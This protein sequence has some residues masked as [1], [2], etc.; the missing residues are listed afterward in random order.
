MKIITLF[1]MAALVGD[2]QTIIED[3]RCAKAVSAT[4]ASPAV[5]T[6][7]EEHGWTGRP[8]QARLAFMS[9]GVAHGTAVTIDGQTYTFVTALDNEQPRQILISG[10]RVKTAQRLVAAIT[11]SGEDKGVGYSMATTAHPT[12]AAMKPQ[13]TEASLQ[14]DLAN[15]WAIWKD[16]GL[17]TGD[18]LTV[19][20]SN[21]ATMTPPFSYYGTYYAIRIDENRFR[22]AASPED[23][24]NGVS[25]D[26]AT[27]PGGN[28]LKPIAASC[29]GCFQPW[30]GDTALIYVYV[31]SRMAGLSGTGIPVTSGN[32]AQAAWST[33]TLQIQFNVRITGATGSW[34]GLGSNSAPKNYTAT[35]VDESRFSVPFNATSAG[36]FSGQDIRIR[37]AN[38]DGSNKIYPTNAEIPLTDTMTSNHALAVHVG[39]CEPSMNEVECSKGY[40]SAD[41]QKAYGAYGNIQ[42]F[43]V[44]GKE[45]TITLK[46]SFVD[47]A[48]FE[49]LAVGELIQVRGYHTYATATNPGYTGAP[50]AA[51]QP[52]A[53]LFA[54]NSKRGFRVT[55]LSPDRKTVK[56]NNPGLAD[57]S[58]TGSCAVTGTC[59][60]GGPSSPDPYI[61]ITWRASP[62]LYLT[63]RNGGYLWPSGYDWWNSKNPLSFNP[64]SNRL[65]YWVRFGKNIERPSN[66]SYNFNWGNYIQTVSQDSM[67]GGSH[68]YHLLS[69][70]SYKDRWQLFEFN[71]APSHQVGAGGGVPWP[72][73]P[74]RGHA[75]YPHWRGGPRSCMEGQ[76]IYYQDSVG[77]KADW[78]GQTLYYSQ[79]SYDYVANEPEEFVRGRSGV[80]AAQRYI[81]GTLTAS[82]GYDILWEAASVRPLSYA[83]RYSTTGSIRAIGWS[84]GIDGGTVLPT[85][86]LAAYNGVIWQSPEMAEADN[87]WVAIRPVAPVMGTTGIGVSPIWI[88]TMFEMGLEVGAS[89]NVSG[90]SGNG[91]ANQ[92][93]APVVAVQP[94]RYYRRYA[95]ARESG[96]AVPGELASIAAA[97]GQC[98]ANFTVPHDLLP[99]WVIEVVGSAN[100]T[101]GPVASSTPKLY[102]I[103]E[104]PSTQTAVFACRGVPDGIH[105]APQGV[106]VTYAVIALPAIAIDAFG[107]GSFAGGG[108]VTAAGEYAGFAELHLPRFSA[109]G[110][111]PA[112][113]ANLLASGGN[114]QVELSWTDLATDET[115]FV[116]ERRTEG[117]DYGIAAILPENST[118]YTD[119]GLA[120]G[121]GYYY[122]IRARNA[123]GDSHDSNEAL[124]TTAPPPG[125]PVAPGNFHIADVLSNRVRLEWTDLSAE[126]TSYEV[127][128][129]IGGGAYQGVA[130]LGPNA[131]EFTATELAPLTPY[132]FRVRAANDLGTS[133][134]VESIQVT[135]L[136]DLARRLGGITST[137]VLVMYQ[138][139]SAAPCTLTIEGSGGGQVE[140][141]GADGVRARQELIKGLLPQTRYLAILRCDGAASSIELTTPSGHTSA[142]SL[143]A[144]IAAPLIP[145]LDNLVVE[146]GPSA[147]ELLPLGN[148]AC[149]TG[150][151]M[152]TLPIVPEDNQWF[153]YRWCRNRAA[154]PACLNPANELSR[155]GV[156][157]Q[158]L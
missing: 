138:A 18:A 111:A 19:T 84:S 72:N 70:N 126:E 40:W 12:V 30:A 47:Q 56:I 92:S 54:K 141:A 107:D 79:F 76:T 104:T 119:V 132:R 98:T 153:R 16:H 7:N 25:M 103:T 100:A 97:G 96:S 108:T 6:C 27:S 53:T 121:V 17:Q 67:G 122:R 127:E 95:V 144:S 151:C 9:T 66:G 37:T 129:S 42:S 149:T 68:F 146:A 102:T 44:S 74:L 21:S 145:G 43:V 109:F 130:H 13:F 75:Y 87:L 93:G 112:G 91:A 33:S 3:F 131:V 24:A 8:A 32:S 147:S 113:P 2:C 60:R 157:A 73:E 26:L 152:V 45:I 135:T 38:G 34:T 89:V 124:G 64:L 78:S 125:P 10:N 15:D 11:D 57:G 117:S 105:S 116:L 143:Q 139:P 120:A 150:R 88:M 35:V 5:L 50:N 65:R 71:C 114:Q 106:G 31:Y 81:Q 123:A 99:G 90:V 46:A 110:N 156:Q 82:A 62:Y 63:N 86:S 36:S 137:A 41:N 59:V 49:P 28:F 136:P 134:W 148:A 155:S 77:G 23:A 140:S 48:T 128:V 1:V 69:M 4:N 58:Y 154:D 101:L 22:V 142:D 29:S 83:V 80:W 55:Y 118:S 52:V 20:S 94:R 51:S 85:S 115:E 61:V 39:G 14:L 133:S 158:L